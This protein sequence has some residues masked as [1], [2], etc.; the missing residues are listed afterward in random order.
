MFAVNENQLIYGNEIAR[1]KKNGRVKIPSEFRKIVFR[2]SKSHNLIIRLDPDHCC[3][4]VRDQASDRYHFFKGAVEDQDIK[5][6]QELCR[7]SACASIGMDDRFYIPPLYRNQAQL[8]DYVIF[9]GTGDG[10][11]IWNPA[12]LLADD[13]CGPFFKSLVNHYV[14]LGLLPKAI[15]AGGVASKQADNGKQTAETCADAPRQSSS[16]SSKA[17]DRTS[18]AE[19]IEHGKAAKGKEPEQAPK[20]DTEQTAAQADQA[21]AENHIESNEKEAPVEKVALS[22]G[23]KKLVY[24]SGIE[25]VL[26]RARRVDYI[27]PLLTLP[28]SQWVIVVHPQGMFS[29]RCVRPMWRCRKVDHGRDTSCDRSFPKDWRDYSEWPGY[30]AYN[31][32][33]RGLPEELCKLFSQN[34]TEINEHLNGEVRRPSS[35]TLRPLLSSIGT[36]VTGEQNTRRGQYGQTIN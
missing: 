31:D 34:R 8:D 33:T 20:P 24:S 1:V 22:R 14:R 10:F 7:S 16:S 13:S 2:N 6:Q 9:L 17:R 26:G 18:E 4:K 35:S 25:T 11:E 12:L 32:K 21:S 27:S 15:V 3:L 36:W 28:D 19:L 5:S 29:E 23:G 30:D